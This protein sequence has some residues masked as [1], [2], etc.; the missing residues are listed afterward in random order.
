MDA[1]TLAKRKER[2]EDTLGSSRSFS[3]VADDSAVHL[4]FA[5]AI[6]GTCRDLEKRYLRLT[7]APDPSTVRPVPVL[8][9][10]LKYVLDKWTKNEE[11]YLYICDQLKAIRQDLTVQCVRD[12]FTVH[13]YETHA[14]I[15]LQKVSY[16]SVVS[17]SLTDISL[18]GDHEEFNQCQSQL[19]TLY[20]EVGG[21]NRREFVAYYI[22]YNIFSENNSE[23]QMLM[24]GLSD[25]DRKDERVKFAL[26]VRAAWALCNYTSLFRLYGKARDEMSRKLMEWFISR[27][28][29]QALRRILKA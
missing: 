2:F 25:E 15:A 28:R 14:R 10:S 21:E 19:R 17:L 16:S 3:Y 7:S 24:K 20:Q 23:L 26:D 8:R 13:V 12:D 18:Q 1:G 27:E 6:V 4:D 5:T 11:S 9:R 29:K 22:L